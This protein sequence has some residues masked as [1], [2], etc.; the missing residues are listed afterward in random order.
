MNPDPTAAELADIAIA[1]SRSAEGVLGEPA[2]VALL[3]FSTRGSAAHPRI[4]KVREALALARGKAPDLAI[5]GELQADAALVPEV[6]A[7]RSRTAAPSPGARTCSC[8]PIS[9][10]ETSR[11]S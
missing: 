3:S 10:P 1:S 5:D 8:S 2:R 9:T 11:T 7:R 4:D 6:A